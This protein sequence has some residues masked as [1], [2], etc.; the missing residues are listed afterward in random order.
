MK[1]RTWTLTAAILY[2]FTSLAGTTPMAGTIISEQSVDFDPLA[3][4]SRAK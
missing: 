2:G 3:D 4:A 1:I